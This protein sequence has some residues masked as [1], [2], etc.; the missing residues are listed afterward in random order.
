MLD[1]GLSG[2][3]WKNVTPPTVAELR[4][5]VIVPPWI[6]KFYVLDLRPKNSF[7]KWAVD[8]GHTVFVICATAF[9]ADQL[10]A[11]PSTHMRR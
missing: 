3:A 1:S 6:N 7:I 4:P 9:F 8:E 5:L 10:N 11:V 2:S